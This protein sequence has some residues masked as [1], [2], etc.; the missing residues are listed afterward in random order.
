MLAFAKWP[1]L[2][3]AVFDG[4]FR[5]D[6]RFVV[7]NKIDS[8]RYS[9]ALLGPQ[10]LVVGVLTTA[11][12]VGMIRGVPHDSVVLGWTAFTLAFS[13]AVVATDLL[14]RFPPPYD[15]KLA[16]E[17]ALDAAPQPEAPAAQAPGEAATERRGARSE[18]TAVIRDWGLTRAAREVR[19]EKRACPSTTT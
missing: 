19:I 7:T 8:S 18:S 14:M 12:L 1:Y 9:P 5:R 15:P 16:D 4:I 11:W 6:T 17:M 3:G 2:I 10:L 13:L